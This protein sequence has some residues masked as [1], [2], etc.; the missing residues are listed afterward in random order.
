MSMR[1]IKDVLQRMKEAGFSA[2]NCAFGMGGGLLQKINRDT[3]SFATKLAH[4]EYADGR[5]RDIMKTPQGDSGKFSLPGELAVKLANGI[6]TVFPADDVT[7]EENRMHTYYDSR[8]REDLKWE[9]FSEIRRRVC[10]EWTALPK[11]HDPISAPLRAKIQR[12]MKQRR[13]GV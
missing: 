4:I 5:S 8:P 2:E 13:N 9:S 10:S 7:A 3:M 6:P 11:K 12:F 1:K